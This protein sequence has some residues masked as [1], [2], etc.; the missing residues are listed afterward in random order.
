M[1][2]NVLNQVADSKDT[3]IDILDL[4]KNEMK[5]GETTMHLLVEGDA[6]IYT[7]LQDL[8]VTYGEELEWLI[9]FP[10]DFH[11]LKNYQ[12]VILK[13]FFQPGLK[14]IAS[15]AGFRGETLTL[16]KKMHKL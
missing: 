1:Y 4:L 11:I 9:P 16:L 7:I 6:K 8:K 15:N 10:G 13:I 5:V 14:Q 2:L 12:E 3:I